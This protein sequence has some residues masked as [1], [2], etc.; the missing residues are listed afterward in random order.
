MKNLVL[1]MAIA[2]ASAGALSACGD[3]DATSDTSDAFSSVCD[4]QESVLASLVAL[5][6]VDGT[7]TT[8]DE[9]QSMVDDLKS[10]VEDLDGA[11][12][13]LVEQ[14]VD[15]VSSAFDS[16]V[17]QVQD[18]GDVPLTE[19]EAEVSAAGQAAIADFR[20]AYE[21]AY[22]SSS[23]TSDAEDDTEDDTEADP[24]DAAEDDTEE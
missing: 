1:V 18:L 5:D 14:D 9:L 8:G 11:K 16:L 12:A 22:E 17:E 10:S 20:T 15:N 6:S 7:E 4:N 21:A 13:D 2:L 3:D 23:C 19:L 24:E